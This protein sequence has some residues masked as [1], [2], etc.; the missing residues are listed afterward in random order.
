M[1][2][3][4]LELARLSATVDWDELSFS[5][6]FLRGVTDSAPTIE[7]W[8]ASHPTIAEAVLRVKEDAER[9]KQLQEELNE[10]ESRLRKAVAELTL[11]CNQSKADCHK[12]THASLREAFF[13]SHAELADHAIPAPVLQ[14]S[15]LDSAPSA[16]FGSSVCGCWIELTCGCDVAGVVRIE[17]TCR[18]VV[19]NAHANLCLVRVSTLCEQIH[20]RIRSSG[21][22]PPEP[23]RCGLVLRKL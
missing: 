11:M 13:V 9:V 2:S 6:D 17:A 1:A 20:D 19:C 14:V 8:R 5:S 16:F 3:T 22:A 23:H 4:L 7:M 18:G 21:M 12:Q 10:R 15:T